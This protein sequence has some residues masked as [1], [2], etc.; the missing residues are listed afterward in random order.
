MSS[1]H[2]SNL[3]K[4]RYSM[5]NGVYVITAVTR[6]RVPRFA[7]LWCGRI[8]VNAMRN[9]AAKGD[10][11]SLAFVVMPDHL[12]WL[13]SLTGNLGLSDLM[14]SVKGYSSHC[15]HSH[16]G[17]NAAVATFPARGPVWQEGYHDHSLRDEEDV[18]MVARY[19]VMNPVRAGLVSNIWNY[20]LWDAIWVE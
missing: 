12:H 5:C 10:V 14:R 16:H 18:R 6:G 3:R 2:G 8:L 20:P 7:D 13:V 4:G 1:H 11:E 17:R 15:L 9:H 19:V